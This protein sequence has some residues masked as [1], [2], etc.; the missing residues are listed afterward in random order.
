M[1][2]SITRRE[3]LKAG[4]V[5]GALPLASMVHAH[6]S[7]RIK[8]GLVGC[9]GR[10]TGAAIDCL[11]ADEGTVIWAMG[12]IFEDR[13]SASYE[14]LKEQFPERVQVASERRFVGFDAYKKVLE[15]GIDLVLLCTPPAF[16]PIHFLAAVEAGTHV[17]ME[18]PVAVCPEGVRMVL[19]GDEIARQKRLGVMPG[20]QY[21]WHPGYQ[22]VIERIRAGHIGEIRAAYAYYNAASPAPRPRE[23]GW[24]DLVYQLRN[25]LFYT[26][27][28]GDQPVEQFVHNIDVMNWVMGSVPVRAMAMGGRQ[29]RT[30]PE[31][32]DVYDHFAIEYEYPN[33]VRVLAMCRQ[34]DN[35]A[36]RVSNL[37][38]GAEG[39][40]LMEQFTNFYVR[41]KETWEPGKQWLNPYVEEHRV[42]IQSIRKGDPINETRTIAESTLT[43]IMG[44]MSAYTGKIV[45]WE[46]ALNSKLNY[47]ERVINIDLRQPRAA[48]PCTDTRQD[49]ADIGGTLSACWALGLGWLRRL[50]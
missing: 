32:G 27:L 41:G 25:W 45:T 30:A 8:V 49:A 21:R 34:M 10:G 16:R 11:R 33:G 31:Y 43:A 26:W 18:K 17:F 42:L 36:Y 14:G 6:G 40:A 47:V 7:D 3:F 29:A 13:L 20:T 37:V 48:R 46:A 5:L 12:D 22:G 19:R 39:Q 2:Q 24:S 28:S 4:V 23:A 35:T 50:R 38:V 1:S 44:R 15:S 9:G